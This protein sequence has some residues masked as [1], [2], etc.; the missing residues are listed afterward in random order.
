M[1]VCGQQP[2][3][4]N[5]EEIGDAP[6][7]KERRKK[8]KKKREEEEIAPEIEEEVRIALQVDLS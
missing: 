1:Y 3:S 4:Q 6:K 2:H 5:P 7:K 8:K